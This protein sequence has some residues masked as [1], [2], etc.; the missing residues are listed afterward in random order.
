[1]SRFDVVVLPLT[2]SHD[3]DVVLS[4]FPPPLVLITISCMCQIAGETLRAL[5]EA[6]D[7]AH[8]AA[9]EAKKRR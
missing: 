6:E 5:R 1:M 4:I 2:F 3:S 7:A 8:A 9:A